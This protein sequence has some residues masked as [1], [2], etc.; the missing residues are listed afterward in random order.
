MSKYNSL[1]HYTDSIDKLIGIL[2][3]GFRY[4]NLKEELPFVG[5]PG[6]PFSIIGVTTY[7][8]KADV[9]CFCDIPFKYVDDHVEQYGGYGIGLNKKW[10]MEQGITPVRYF[11]HYTP[12]LQDV[13]IHSA[14][15]F[16]NVKTFLKKTPLEII[17]EELTYK[18]VIKNFTLKDCDDIPF[19]L[20]KILDMFGREYEN[21]MRYVTAQ[22][23]YLRAYEGKWTDR[24]T[25]KE[26]HRTFYYEH[27]WRAIQPNNKPEYLI[28]PFEQL[29][30]IIV[31][32]EKEKNDIIKLDVKLEKIVFLL[33]EIKK[34]NE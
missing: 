17:I 16:N 13:G 32:D 28:F 12:D 23:E 4:N 6:S 19:E 18:K 10:C 7:H 11:H 26:T 29:E 1:T 33:S 34:S 25:Q 24:T 2:N 8:K 14:M 9:V 5:F 3:Y 21:A 20:K 15:T 31:K 30:Y 22:V 27:E